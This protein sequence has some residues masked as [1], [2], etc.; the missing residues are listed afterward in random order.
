[1][2]D[3]GLRG[4]A[5]HTA[6]T[7]L[8]FAGLVA[9]ST[10]V[11]SA[12]SSVTL[13]WDP[14]ASAGVA[15][16][17][18]YYGAASHTYTNMVAAGNATNVTVSGLVS[19][20]T[21]YF[22]ATAY[23]SFGVESDYSS[24]TNYTVPS[25]GNQAPTLNPIANLTINENASQQT[26]NLTGITSGSPAENQTLTVSASSDNTALVPNPSV[27]YTSPNTTGTLRFT[28]ANNAT[29]L[30]TI[31]VT[32]NDG[33]ASNNITTR[34]FKVTVNAVNTPPTITAIPN[35]TIA[36]DSSSAAIPF[37]VGDA[38]TSA[39]SLTV[40]AGSSNPSVVPVSGIAFA[41]S[42]ANRTV[43][44]TP[45]AGKSGASTV[46]VSV[47]DGT[48]TTSANFLVTVEPASSPSLTI[49][50]NGNGKV[51]PNPDTLQVVA[52]H[53]YT[54]TATPDSGS[55]F[56]N[57]TGTFNSDSATITVTVTNNIALQA[58]FV[59]SPFLPLAGTYNGLFYESDQVR[60]ASAGA[61]T[62]SLNTRGKYSG[63]VQL[64]S[65]RYAFSGKLTLGCVATNA[66]KRAKTLSPLTLT[67]RVGT[68]GEID[69]I[70]GNVTDGTWISGLTGDRA[71]YNSRTNPAPATGL[72]TFVIPGSFDSTQPRGH[73]YGTVRVSTGGIATWVGALS[74]SAHLTQSAPLSKHSVWP[75]YAS[76][77]GGSESVLS[78]LTFTNQAASDI[79][80]QLSWI[81]SAN[82]K[83]RYFSNGFDYVS[84]AAGSAFH[85]PGTNDILTA[86]DA[87]VD[88]SGGNLAADFSNIVNIGPKNKV[89][90]MSNNKL[91]LAFG[92][93]NGIYHGLVTDPNT[94]KTMPYSGVVFQKQNAGYG[95]LLGTSLSSRVD[96]SP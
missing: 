42:G 61:V 60:Q 35:Q 86:G 51:T 73:S 93:A 67:L 75:V 6:L 76:I 79:S 92:L 63:K 70:F 85:P 30:A 43:T 15:G 89:T 5:R 64:G 39:G 19:G 21:Y 33:G 77:A 2:Y 8:L 28:P 78:W 45:A 22:A 31:T 91:S 16:Y 24:E 18:I 7:S 44:I 11:A 96:L 9:I 68:N 48:A 83:S 50:I 34:T 47:S 41:G 69:Q 12:A 58:N 62:L 3:K 52:G 40:S 38:Q 87:S 14:S 26:V 4:T 46:T 55:E 72:Y 20:A 23:D 66:L 37:T 1:M 27:T 17:N 95:F 74:D 13:A 94:G 71:V 54:F 81:K 56:Q 82:S 84:I 57:W 65:K 10:Q 59:V 25:S 90:N 36:Q 32:V 80:G 88:F 29:G 53:S 49:T